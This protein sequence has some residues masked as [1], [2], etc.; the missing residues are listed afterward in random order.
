MAHRYPALTAVLL[1]ATSAL[2]RAAE[3]LEVPAGTFL[4]IES[5]AG[6]AAGAAAGIIKGKQDLEFKQGA[7]L[8]FETLAPVRVPAPPQ[9]ERKTPKGKPAS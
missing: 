7:R 4:S 5:G 1:L 9:P 6:A 3:V 2:G 8:L